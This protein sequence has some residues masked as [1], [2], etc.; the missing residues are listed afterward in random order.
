M[1]PVGYKPL[2]ASLTAVPSDAPAVFDPLNG[3]NPFHML[4]N[5]PD[6]TLSVHGGQP[7]G[8]CGF[9]MTVNANVVTAA[10]LDL[11]FAIPSSNTVVSNYLAYNGGQDVGVV[12]SSLIPY[13]HNVGLWGSTIQGYGSVDFRDFEE[14][15][16]YC[17]AFLG[18]C[19]GIAVT[20]AMERATQNG[21]PWDF[22]GSAADQN[23]LGGHDVFVFGRDEQGLGILATWGQ[24][25][26]FTQRWW[27]NLVEECDAVVTAEIVAA[28]GDGLN[29]D[30]GQLDSYLNN[31]AS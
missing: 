8:D 16:A 10:G 3:A 6:P 22:T 21:E 26:L 9:V 18:L 1:R 17:H 13:W 11:P 29:L 12:N 27:E 5:G 28:K 14:A 31:I 30:L 23:V 15:M 7:V 25:Q 24:R 4:G 2:A 19:T 20:E